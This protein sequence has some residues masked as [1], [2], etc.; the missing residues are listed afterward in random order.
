MSTA[1][2]TSYLRV[3]VT[4]AGHRLRLTLTGPLDA[5]TRTD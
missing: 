2:P 5:V 1:G 3:T 4:V